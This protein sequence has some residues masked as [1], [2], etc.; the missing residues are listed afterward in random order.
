VAGHAPGREVS[1]APVFVKMS[2]PSTFLY[3]HPGLNPEIAGVS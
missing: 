1:V 2:T 3:R